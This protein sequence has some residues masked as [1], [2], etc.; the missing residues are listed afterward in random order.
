MILKI[1][2]SLYSKSK[3][4]SIYEW[5]SGEESSWSTG[6][7]RRKLLETSFC[8]CWRSAPMLVDYKWSGNKFIATTKKKGNND[9]NNT[10]GIYEVS[11]GRKTIIPYMLHFPLHSFCILNYVGQLLVLTL[12]RVTCW[13]SISG[14]I[15]WLP[16]AA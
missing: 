6:E 12:I 16:V 10:S 14:D 9:D 13:S 15:C 1:F 4:K 3:T 11:S 7:R 2:F 8:I 5:G